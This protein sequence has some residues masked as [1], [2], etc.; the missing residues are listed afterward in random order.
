[1]NPLIISDLSTLADIEAAIAAVRHSGGVPLQVS[2]DSVNKRKGAMHDAARL[3]VLVTWAR[4]SNERQLHFHAANDVNAVMSELC[5][6]APGITALRLADGITVGETTVERRITLEGAAEKMR[7][8]DAMQLTEIVKGRTIDLTCVSGS[9]VQYLRPLFSSRNAQSV[10][11][12]E[13]MHLLLRALNDQINQDDAGLV[14]ASFLRACGVFTSEL[15]ANTQEHATRDHR[16][17]L[18]SAHVEGLIVSW[19]QMDEALYRSDFQGHERLR[20]FWDSEATFVRGG[21]ARA[22]RGLQLSFFDSGPGFASRATGLPTEDMDRGDERAELLKCLRKSVTTKRESGAGQGLPG[23]LAEL[24]AI[25]GLIRIR[26][27]RHSVFN[28]FSPGD[29]RDVFDFADWTD[30][31]LA[32]ASGAVVSLLIPLRKK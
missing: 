17:V 20:A 30:K 16:G 29:T 13:G 11:K 3:Q 1:M 23:V 24:S 27:G 15:F 8:T 6:Y 22:L 32:G 19:I 2:K 12:K 4:S 25:G 26:S 21:A 14:P 7:Q 28:A 9:R 10:K 5:D 31:D 18:F